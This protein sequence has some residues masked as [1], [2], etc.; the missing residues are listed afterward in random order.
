MPSIFGSIEQGHEFVEGALPE[1][2]AAELLQHPLPARFVPRA[3]VDVDETRHD[4]AAS[5]VG[6]YIEKNLSLRHQLKL[7]KDS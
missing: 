1:L 6:L 7:A 3:G 5:P 4:H 2:R